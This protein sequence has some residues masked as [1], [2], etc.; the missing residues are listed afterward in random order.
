MEAFLSKTY[1]CLLYQE[2]IM[3]A[4]M[5][6]GGYDSNEADEVRKI[7]GKKKV[8]KVAAAG[9]EFTTRAVER[10]MDPS[11]A[12]A[13]WSQ[14][15]EFAKYSFNRAHAYAYAVLG[16]WCAWLKFHFPVEYLTAAM[17]TVDADRIPDFVK[18]ARRMGYQVLPPDINESG[19][20]FTKGALQVRYGL[21]QIKGIGQGGRLIVEE[22]T[23]RGPFTSYENFLDRL[24]EPKDSKVNMGHVRTLAK[25]GAFDSLVPNRRGLEQMLLDDKSGASTRCVWKTDQP[26]TFV[27]TQI[28]VRRE[29]DEKVEE[30]VQHALPC[31]FDWSSEPIPVNPRTGKKSGAKPKPPVAR[32]TKG[33]RHYEAPPPVVIA[34]VEPYT[35]ADIRDIEAELLG[36]FLSSTPFDMLPQAEREYTR[37][38]ADLMLT[39]NG[40]GGLYLSAGALTKVRPHT[41]KSSGAK[42]GFVAFETEAGVVDVTVF[43]TQWA[44]F[45]PSLKTGGF[46]VFEVNRN[47]KGFTLESLMPYQP[48]ANHPTPQEN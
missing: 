37:A 20:G 27:W 28:K 12:A 40:P 30:A 45:Q 23:A 42:M 34:D 7:L 6:L 21:S 26:D 10:G 9:Q 35:D 36:V 25:I 47:S 15:A 14:M 3:Q 19:A 48:I 11:A 29:G 16:Y 24:V 2:D 4:C 44:R 8:E 1:G 32:C 18:E 22:R 38:Q 43:A 46:Y 13:L 5:V 39:P 33:C 41:V 31:S 17:T